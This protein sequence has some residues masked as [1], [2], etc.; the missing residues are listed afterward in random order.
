MERSMQIIKQFI[1]DYELQH[2]TSQGLK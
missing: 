1:S 2:T